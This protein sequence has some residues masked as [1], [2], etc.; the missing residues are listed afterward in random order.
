MSSELKIGEILIKIIIILVTAKLFGWLAEKLKQPSVLGELLAG[1]LLGP[2]LFNLINPYEPTLLFSII[3]FLGEIG[4]ILLLFQVGLESNIYQLL[5]SGMTSTLVAIIG[6]VA[7]VLM[8]IGFAMG[9]M[10]ITD[11]NVALLIGATLAAT[12]VGITMRVLS[13]MK[14]TN[15]EE[16]KIILGAAVIDD[17]LGLIILSVIAGLVEGGT[18]GSQSL[19]SIIGLNTLYSVLFLVISIW[20]GIK[21]TP[22]IYKI[23]KRM[24]I[25]RTF[26]VSSFIFML[27]L[28][29]IADY[30]GLAT[31]V[32]AF[33]AG[34]VFE[35]LEE[36]EHYEERIQP[37]ANIFVPI[38]F[39]VA[40]LY[41]D[42][43]AL[44]QPGIIPIVL[45]LTVIA[46]I[47]KL[48]AGWG[49]IGAGVNK[50]AIG[51][52]MVPRG[53]VGL[54]FASFGLTYGLLQAELYSALVIVVM[55]TTLIAPPLL[56]I[57]MKK[58]K[59]GGEIPETEQIF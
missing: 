32:G 55:L 25:G 21:Y 39:V 1:V 23:G 51:I 22:L 31:I 57:V 48:I 20:V 59:G 19:M 11:F 56:L 15:T 47:G 18:H 45:A 34:L 50:L 17:I 10:K 46:I 44:M 49:A 41:L 5:K 26:V 36:K 52:G 8:G 35:R 30:I 38:F 37:V 4:V 53:E 14:K 16:G 27:I 33:A 7:P 54:I 13:D 2:S 40:G 3:H 6:V 43:G 9:L 58:V 29:A 42:V 28:S 24:K 12:S